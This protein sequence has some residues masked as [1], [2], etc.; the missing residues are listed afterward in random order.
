MKEEKQ[1]QTESKQL[2]DL[3][4]NSIYS[5]REIFLRELISNASDAI[6]K[7]RFLSLTDSNG[8]PAKEHFIRLEANKDARTI[9]ITDN[10]IGMTKE[11]MEQ[12]LGT[13][14]KSGS[15]D[16][17][18]KFK[19]AKEA[20][21]LSI[22]GQFGVGFYSA[23][24]VAD[25]VEVYSKSVGCPAY[26]F[27]SDGKET[28]SIEDTEFEGESGTK[29]VVYLKKDT[30]DINYSSFLETW[31]IEELVRKYSDYVRYPIKM[32]ESHSVPA[33]DENG[34]EIKGKTTEVSED[35]T[36]NSMVPLWKK[37]N[38]EVDDKALAE[39][40]KNK[41]D[42]FED[43]LVS[44]KL[45][46][47]G[48]VSYDALL[49]IPS[50]APYNLY[51]ESYERGLNLY[52]KGIFIQEKCKELI[53]Q[54]LKFVQGLVD[55]DDFPLN[56]SREMLQNSPAMSK[57]ATS[58]EKKLIEKLKSMSKNEPEKYEKFFSLY[59]DYIKYGIYSSYGMK[60]EEL[61]DLLL[62][63]HT[64]DDKLIS[65]KAYV[66][67][68][69]EGQKDI[70]YASGKS[71]AEVKL[72]PQLEKYKKEGKD[73]LLLDREIDEFCLMAMNEYDK[74][75]YK[76][77]SSVSAEEISKEEK[78]KL[79]SLTASHKRILDDLKESL[80]GK[81]DEVSFSTKLVDSP[82]CI[83]TKN[84]LSLNMEK[85]LEAQ[86]GAENNPNAP[87]ATK[88]LEI[89]ADSPLFGAIA[90]LESD[91]EIKKYGSL[92]YNEALLLEGFDIEDKKE[93]VASLNELL[94]KS[95]K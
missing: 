40:Y 70:F 41:F 43:P 11:E 21:D 79:D 36:L 13:I 44:L 92:L 4:I 31:K 77:I 54:Y 74:H 47:E 42:D 37:A 39:F 29:V 71:L 81:V 28:Y 63:H 51:S 57:I 35:K 89:N 68:L 75:P 20:Q 2:L 38:S 5:N 12:N 59:G 9:S 27:V 69:K 19:E 26:K 45:R 64:A 17:A 86:P 61:K 76:N 82:V 67:A 18:A 33:K 72:L 73:V 80:N 85:V 22:I 78:D 90:K 32:M 65:L 50:H 58:V 60:G 49:F 94:L 14:A 6:D 66:D 56:I 95:A 91:D 62:F 10:G 46:V 23:F 84:G 53:P 34:K 88:V 25:K 55:S 8:H 93:F 30:E 48:L 87:K 24:M 83:T 7:Y 16:F 3:M 15:K 52:S 1:F